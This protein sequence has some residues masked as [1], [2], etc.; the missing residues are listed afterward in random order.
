LRALVAAQWMSI[1]STFASAMAMAQSGSRNLLETLGGSPLPRVSS[2]T[3]LPRSISGTSSADAWAGAWTKF[4]DSHPDI[5]PDAQASW[6]SMASLSDLDKVVGLPPASASAQALAPTDSVSEID[7]R[8][9]PPSPVPPVPPRA[10]ASVN[11]TRHGAP[12]TSAGPPQTNK[13]VSLMATTARAIP[14]QPSRPQPVVIAKQQVKPQVR[15]QVKPLL[16]PQVRPQVKPQV[17][18]QAKPQAKKTE[19]IV[20]LAAETAPSRKRKAAPSTGDDASLSKDEIN[21]RKKRTKI[22]TPTY[23]PDV[24][25][26]VVPSGGL[27]AGTVIETELRTGQVVKLTINSSEAAASRSTPQIAI[28]LDTPAMVDSPSAQYKVSLRGGRVQWVSRKK[29]ETIL[30]NRRSAA[31][32]RNV[33][34]DLRLQ[35]DKMEVE[36]KK[37]DLQ[38]VELKRLL[39]KAGI[40]H[41]V[42]T[43]PRGSPDGT[44]ST[45]TSEPSH[46]SGLILQPS[47]GIGNSESRSPGRIA[48]KAKARLFRTLSGGV[49]RSAPWY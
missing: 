21:F 19:K 42:D 31:A 29:L 44:S 38:I 36:L 46:K 1:G 49:K 47:T 24:A 23:I 4:L 18:P 17:K 28:K 34:V 32:T 5:L 27:T 12:R 22:V 35:M 25:V 33:V 15:P 7:A 37:K 48:E 30:R 45:V 8:V 9:P 43:S 3:P 10:I 16:K 41:S 20:K 11:S 26:V 2:G 13:S 40:K 6:G 14:G 39:A